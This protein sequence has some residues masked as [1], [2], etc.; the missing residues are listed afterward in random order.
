MDSYY[1]SK[2]E[3]DKEAKRL[4][5][6]ARWKS[7]MGGGEEGGESMPQQSLGGTPEEEEFA[8]PHDDI[9]TQVRPERRKPVNVV[10][11]AN[12]QPTYSTPARQPAP[13]IRGRVHPHDIADY[14]LKRVK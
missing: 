5:Q 9:S 14:I 1:K 11:A 10:N 3:E 13:A 2:K 6:L 8:R 12:R 4:A 7:E